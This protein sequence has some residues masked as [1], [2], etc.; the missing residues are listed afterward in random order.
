M[1]QGALDNLLG[2]PL[3]RNLKAYEPALAEINR[4]ED[5]LL[6]LTEVELRREAAKA[7]ATVSAGVPPHETLA[8]T[9][10]LVREVSHRVLGL[11]PFGVQMLAGLALHAGRVVEMQTGEGKTL[12]A[13]APVCLAAFSR[14]GVHVLTFNDYLAHRDANWM[15]PIYEFFGLSV[16]Y[17]KQG[18]SHEERRKA[19]DAEVT[20]VTAKEAGFDYLRDCLC[21]DSRDRVHRPFH[22][23]IVDEADAL[24]IDEARVPLVIAGGRDELPVD[25]HRLAEIVRRLEPERHFG[26]D[27][28]LRTVFLTDEG[29]SE[30]ERLLACGDVCAPRNLLLLAALNQALH[31]ETLVRRDV[32]YIVR[33]GRIELVDEFTGRVVQDR[34]WPDGLQSAIEAKEGLPINSEGVILNSITLQHFTGLYPNIA[35]MTGTAQDAAEEF[36]EFYKLKTVVIPTNRPCVRTDAPDRVFP[37]RDA[38]RQA[39]V[40]EIAR[41]HATGRPILVGTAS[42]EE[43]EQLA[44]LLHERGIGCQVLNAKNDFLEAE[45]M[46]QAGSLG[47]V[48][49]STNMAGRGVD[50]KL[51]PHSCEEHDAVASLGGL[52]VIGTNRHESR[53]IDRQLRGRAGR[54]GDPGSST[55]YVSL[56]DNLVERYGMQEMIHKALS[57]P[58]GI[59]FSAGREI[60]RAQRIIEG[61]NLDIRKMMFKYSNIVETQRCL[62]Q[63]K[64]DRIQRENADELT[65]GKWPPG[66]REE[67]AAL[68]GQAALAESERRISLFHLDRTW[69]EYLAEVAHF[70]EGLHLMSLGRDPLTFF[71]EAAIEA[72]SDSLLRLELNIEETL[73][74]IHIS[75]D[76]I[77]LGAEGLKAPSS[78]W[79]YLIN[80]DPWGPLAERFFRGLDRVYLSPARNTLLTLW[81]RLRKRGR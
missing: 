16:G 33:N 5:E 80:D 67:A 8:R 46:S 72:F 56:E 69:S 52:L 14:H 6:R 35:G 66:K 63:E 41:V 23:C 12:A 49:I 18:M 24:L 20:Y 45:T 28:H 4:L 55:F 26:T 60:E 76:G 34:R 57:G 7:L 77:D 40:D 74:R 81:H 58:S 44:D 68:L 10:A 78:T 15:R 13:V 9:F 29:L 11:R 32:D 71:H 48:T 51:G 50:I 25:P 73:R 65:S 62:L 54:Q 36:R 39:L 37:T 21:Y 70:R 17:V 53:R 3:E 38:K 43:S 75:A 27:D 64:R 79:T 2:R 59:E 31:A 61:Q 1:H 47:A 19:Y 22:A 30:A 42:V